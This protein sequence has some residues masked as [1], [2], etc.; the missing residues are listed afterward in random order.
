MYVMYLLSKTK[1]TKVKLGGGLEVPLKKNS[2]GNTNN[3]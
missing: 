1:E 2:S 3:Y